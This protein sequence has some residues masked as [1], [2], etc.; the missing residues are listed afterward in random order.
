MQFMRTAANQALVAQL[1]EAKPLAE[2]QE[3]AE[4]C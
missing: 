1:E 3:I 2:V 4:E